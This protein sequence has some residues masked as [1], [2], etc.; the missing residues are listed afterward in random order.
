M[1]E[2][3]TCT[4]RSTQPATAGLLMEPTPW[5]IA[6]QGTSRDGAAAARRA[7]TPKVGGSSPSPATVAWWPA[8][9][10]DG[11]PVNRTSSAG[12]QSS[13]QTAVT[14]RDQSRS[15]REVTV[16]STIHIGLQ[17]YFDELNQ[18][19]ARHRGAVLFEGIGSLT[20]EEIA[21]LS[22]E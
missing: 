12:S 18:V 10:A 3:L 16:V 17:S 2:G 22:P 13:L 20:E 7:H 15:A 14:R 6:V 1:V 11:A 8:R 21:A 5:C 9:A 19:I 4:R